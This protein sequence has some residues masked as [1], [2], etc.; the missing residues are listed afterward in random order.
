MFPSTPCYQFFLDSR[1]TED[2]K[3]SMMKFQPS[4]TR[5]FLFFA[6]LSR[7][8]AFLPRP[9]TPSPTVSHSPSLS[10]QPFVFD[11][12]RVPEPIRPPSFL[13]SAS[14]WLISRWSIK[15][16][17]VF[18][19]PSKGA[20]QL[21]PLVTWRVEQPLLMVDG[22]RETGEMV[23]TGSLAATGI[24]A[25]DRG[26]LYH[27]LRTVLMPSRGEFCGQGTVYLNVPRVAWVTLFTG[28]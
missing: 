28:G 23:G 25:R 27:G 12:G 9:L 2:S 13:A 21:N 11:S 26:N 15:N 4:A 10:F 3:R 22:R 6:H 19:V 14:C 5:F 7:S 24:R 1:F 17:F 16:S 18:A 8:L 20:A